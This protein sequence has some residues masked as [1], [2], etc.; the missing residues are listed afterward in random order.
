MVKQAKFWGYLPSKTRIISDFPGE[1]FAQLD[2][3]ATQIFENLPNA[4]KFSC[5]C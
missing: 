1:Y 4:I 2:C 5:T 3:Y